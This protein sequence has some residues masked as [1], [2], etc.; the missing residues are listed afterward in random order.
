MFEQKKNASLSDLQ[1]FVG[2][3]HSAK[4]KHRQKYFLKLIEE[5][6]ELSE[7]IK[8]DKRPAPGSGKVKAIKNTVE[9]EMA[10][11]LYFLLALA[12]TYDIDLQKTFIRKQRYNSKYK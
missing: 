7:M 4:K 9:E 10:D 5:V 8:E 3:Q 12:N 11:V 1:T 6:G 2:E